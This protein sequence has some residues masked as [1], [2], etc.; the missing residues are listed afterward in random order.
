MT[1]NFHACILF[2]GMADC[3]LVN[4][5][6]TAS[7]FASTFTTLHAKGIKPEVLYPAV[8]IGQFP[9]NVQSSTSEEWVFAGFISVVV[10]NADIYTCRRLYVAYKL[11]YESECDD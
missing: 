1:R 7:T 10:M 5:K 3:V 8:N 2:T 6:F 4:S 9:V 11:A